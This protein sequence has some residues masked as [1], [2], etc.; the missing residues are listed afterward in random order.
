MKAIITLIILLFSTVVYAGTYSCSDLTKVGL[1]LTQNMICYK[2][3][4]SMFNKTNKIA[5][6]TVEHSFKKN[7]LD[8]EFERTN[9]FIPD[10]NFDKK[11]QA[12]TKDYA[13]TDYDRGHLV[14]AA[15]MAFDEQTMD[16]CFY[17]TNIV[18]QNQNMNRNIWKKLEE[19]TRKWVINKNDLYIITGDISCIGKCQNET[20]IISNNVYRNMN[21]RQIMTN[22]V[23]IPRF[24]YKILYDPKTKQMIAFVMPNVELGKDPIKKYVTTVDEVEKITGL[25]FFTKNE[26]PFEGKVDSNYWN[27]K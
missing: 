5:D 13:G 12:A 19:Q 3:Y 16:E 10:P 24:M 22:N 2:S 11:Y 4:A 25:D 23:V 27:L 21:T 26:E 8:Q 18:P 1:P 17:L 15:N 6:Y 14:P 9:K 7:I 20:I